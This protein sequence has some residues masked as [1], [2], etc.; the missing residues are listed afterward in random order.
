MFLGMVRDHD[1]ESVVLEQMNDK[2]VSD[3]G[4]CASNYVDL[5]RSIQVS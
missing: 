3:T 2:S 5:C 1:F 4:T